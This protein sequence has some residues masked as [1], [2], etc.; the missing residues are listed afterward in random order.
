MVSQNEEQVQAPVAEEASIEPETEAQNPILAEI[1]SLNNAP[2][3]DITPV[4]EGESEVQEQAPPVT[5]PEPVTGEVAAPTE[6]VTPE[7]SDSTPYGSMTPE[8]VQ[9]FQKQATEYEQLKQK[10]V[11]QQETDRY[12]QTL[13]SQG[14]SS[15]QA[16]ESAQQYMQGRQSQQGLMQKAEEYGQHILGKVAASEHFAQKY[17]LSM[18]DLGALRQADSP[19]VM[20]QIAKKMQEDRKLRSE[21]DQ[22]RKA[23]VPVQQFDN[24]QGEPK[25]AANESSWLDRY[26]AGDRSTNAVSA[27]RKAAGLE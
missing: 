7:P 8:Q 2:D 12:K 23:Q 17:N 25:V 4:E 16:T 14:Y 15:E 10:A 19:E 27:A 11:I 6:T 13:E 24:S 3:I 21:L 26:N 20:E 18:S 22:L 9:E 1:E 5:A